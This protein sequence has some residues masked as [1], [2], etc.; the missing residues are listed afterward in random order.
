MKPHYVIAILLPLL[1]VI[2]SGCSKTPEKG[3]RGDIKYA[4]EVN[5]VNNLKQIGFAFKLW[6]RDHNE[7][8]P[9][10]LSTNN[11]GTLELISLDHDGFDSNAFLYLKTMQ[12]DEGLA[13]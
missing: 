11:A 9:F 6:S 12:G 2:F 8:F 5:C 13:T 1:L 10:Q 4:Y 7:K 3:Q